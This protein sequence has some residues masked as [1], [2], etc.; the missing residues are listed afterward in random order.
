MTETPASSHMDAK[1]PENRYNAHA[2]IT[3][4]PAIGDGTWIGA[5]TVIDASG[6]L[7]IGSGCDR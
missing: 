2:W 6:G 1:V 7:T 3:G 4:S 5:F